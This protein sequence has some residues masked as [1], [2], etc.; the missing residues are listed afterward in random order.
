MFR[1]IIKGLLLGITKN[2]V[3]REIY[4]C[5]SFVGFDLGSLELRWF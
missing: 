5:C 4:L 3:E 2:K 1:T